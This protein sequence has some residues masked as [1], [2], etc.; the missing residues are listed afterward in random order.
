MWTSA[1][2]FKVLNNMQTSFM[3]GPSFILHFRGR[4]G[5]HM[6]REGAGLHSPVRRRGQLE[7]NRHSR[8]ES[9]KL[10]CIFLLKL[11]D[12]KFN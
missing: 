10:H 1:K 7:R 12:I 8:L 3:K 9:M 4:R 11:I 6:G 5:V 2:V